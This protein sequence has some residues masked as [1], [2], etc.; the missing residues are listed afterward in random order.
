MNEKTLLM[1]TRL[2]MPQPRKNYIIR[3]ELFSKLDNIGEYSVIL[4]KGCAGSGKTTLITSFAKEKA[5]LNIKW[6]SLDESCNNAFMFW[7]YFIEAIYEFLGAAKQDF[8]SLY[9]SNFQKSNL[10]NLLTLLINE[11]DNLEDIFIVLD[12]FY[13]VTDSFLLHTLDFFLKNVSNN[14]H[15]ILLTRQEP[16]LYLGSLNMEGRLLVISENDLKLPPESGIRFLK[17]TL[18][19]NFKPETLD[20]IN[21][22]SEGWIGG[23]QLVAAATGC[24]SENEIMNLDLENRLVGE[25]LTKEIYDFLN[26]EEKEFLVVTSMLS[27]FNEGICTKLLDN[28]DFKNIMY[29]L[30]GKNILIICIDEKNGI[31]RYHNILREY[32]KERFKGFHRSVQIQFH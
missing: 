2:K 14:V 32:L 5:I 1:G 8:I 22:V 18:K 23:L 9:D 21:S 25:Y 7:N 28:L 4:V 24:K 30:L 16:P 13:Y 26:P 12:D 3:N 10:E 17:D 11:L 31:Y 15:L 6:I 19:L 29:G 27:Y 20:F